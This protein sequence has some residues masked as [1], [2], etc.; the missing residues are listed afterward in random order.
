EGGQLVRVGAPEHQVQQVEPRLGIA[1]AVEHRLRNGKGR[2]LLEL[3]GHSSGHCNLLRR[4]HAPAQHPRPSRSGEFATTAKSGDFSE[5]PLS[6]TSPHGSNPKLELGA[7]GGTSFDTTIRP[8]RAWSQMRNAV[9]TARPNTSAPSLTTS[10]A[11]MPMRT[12]SGS[13]TRAAFERP[14]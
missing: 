3:I 14:R 7:S 9:M 5:N 2:A 6:V 1:A 8:S 11:A 12:K 13:F 4:R 10:P